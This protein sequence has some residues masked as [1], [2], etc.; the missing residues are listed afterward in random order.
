MG[1]LHNIF[2]HRET[3]CPVAV[4]FLPT[5]RQVGG[6]VMQPSANVHTAHIQPEGLAR[7]RAPAPACSRWVCSFD[8]D[9]HLLLCC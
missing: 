6:Q 7:V 4:H 3:T 8:L 1:R 5:P 9:P 2:F